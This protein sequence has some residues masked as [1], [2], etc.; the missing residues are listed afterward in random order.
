MLRFP[1]LLCLLA[2]TLGSVAMANIIPTNTGITGGGPFLW[3]YDVK[4]SADQNAVSGPAPV[5]NPVLHT[6]TTI[7]AFFT[8][9]DF[10]GYVNGTCAGPAGWA[11]TVQNTGFT[12][13]DVTPTD[14]ANIVNITWAYTS[15]ATILGQTI[16][17]DLGLFTA[18]STFNTPV[19]VSYTSR[20]IANTGSQV[21]TIADNVGNT[22]GPLSGVPEPATLGT[23][24]V[25]LMLLGTLRKRAKS[26]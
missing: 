26:A 13:D 20:G 17:K 14:N 23:I 10:A 22:T 19:L 8:I 21:G 1:L 9:Y 4:L 11:C 6:N 24:G 5:A 25:G 7:A 15:G 2:L 16:G 3:T 18:T 12:P